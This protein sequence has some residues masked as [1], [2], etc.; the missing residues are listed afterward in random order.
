MH[1]TCQTSF[2]GKTTIGCGQGLGDT[3]SSISL[4]YINVGKQKSATKLSLQVSDS[5]GLSRPTFML[6]KIVGFSRPAY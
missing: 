3:M 6:Y 4:L 5:K 1:R 2:D